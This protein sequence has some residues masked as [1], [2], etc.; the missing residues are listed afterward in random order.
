MKLFEEDGLKF[1][2]SERVGVLRRVGGEVFF[3]PDSFDRDFSVA[4]VKSLDRSFLKIAYPFA[5]SGV[6][7]LRF[8]LVDNKDVFVSVNDSSSVAVDVIRK[9]FELNGVSSSKYEVSNDDA[10]KFLASHEGFDF[11]DVD[12]FGSPGFFLDV[13]LKRIS[14]GGFISLKATDTA[15]LAGVYNSA[16]R[17][18]YFARSYN[19]FLCHEFGVRIL[20]RFAQLMG[21]V[22]GKALFPVFSF[23]F[24]NFVRVCFQV[25]KGRVL[26][27]EILKQ[28]KLAFFNK[29][30]LSVEF[31]VSDDC[32]PV[33]PLWVG[34]LCDVGFLSKVLSFSDD[35]SGFVKCLVDE[36]GFGVGFFDSHEICSFLSLKFSP[37]I[38]DV[39]S[40]LLDRGFRAVRTHFSDYGFKTDASF[41]VVKEV[42]FEL[43]E[44]K[45]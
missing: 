13:V 39:I 17:R 7:A 40:C 25:K 30:N 34:D 20:I 11:V 42:F 31:E 32:V 33:G 26:C 15:A 43:V 29:S 21:A 41:D 10:V 18:K 9:N 44:P 27:D 5:G 14:R 2:S 23:H 38:S 12:C 6:R 22:N 45:D 16:C 24:K 37:K 8:C 3:N 36:Q 28:H 4:F 19:N 1:F 35:Y